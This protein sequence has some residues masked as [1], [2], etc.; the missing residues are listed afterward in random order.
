MQKYPTPADIRQ[1][2]TEELHA[3]MVAARRYA[4]EMAE[5]GE[6]WDEDASIHF[7]QEGALEQRRR[8]DP[9]FNEPTIEGSRVVWHEDWFS[10][11]ELEA[12]LPDG[13]RLRGQML[14]PDL[15]G[16]ESLPDGTQL[17]LRGKPAWKRIGES[18]E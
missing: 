8:V 12:V 16:F 14:T 10:P 11:A 6:E 7:L 4:N 3:A 2:T 18:D 13:T 17:L 9:H 5:K 1:M 15:V